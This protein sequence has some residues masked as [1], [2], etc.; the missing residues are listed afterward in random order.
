MELWR[1]THCCLLEPQWSPPRGNLW[2]Q[3]SLSRVLLFQNFHSSMVEAMEIFGTSRAA[4]VPG[5]P[6]V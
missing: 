5:L 4:E 2:S 6:L 3:T 1:D